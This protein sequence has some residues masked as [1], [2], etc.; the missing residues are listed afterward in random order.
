MTERQQQ[1]GAVPTR[2][3]AWELEFEDAWE[4]DDQRARLVADMADYF[5]SP[6]GWAELVAGVAPWH[7][8]T[9]A[10]LDW[11]ALCAT[12]PCPDLQPAVAAA[13]VV[14]LS[15]IACAAYEVRRV[16]G[17]RAVRQVLPTALPTLR[18][19][20]PPVSTHLVLLSSNGC[21]LPMVLTVCSSATTFSL[22]GAVPHS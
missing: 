8:R 10:E 21:M 13:P 15:C 17:W 11:Q 1:C 12:C 9:I 22:P 6:A 5:A 2:P 19:K 4:A 20:R 18:R 3:A 7:G 14:A 16:L